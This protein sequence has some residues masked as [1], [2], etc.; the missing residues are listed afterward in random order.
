MPVILLNPKKFLSTVHCLVFNRWLTLAA[1]LLRI[2]IASVSPTTQLCQ[3]VKFLMGHY[4][5]MWFYIRIHSSCVHG[6][7]NFLHS[8]Q[9]L[10]ALPQDVQNVIQPVVQRNAY[11]AHPEAVLLAMSADQDPQV[12]ARAVQAIQRC[13]EQPPSP[14]LR[15]FKLPSVNFAA[16]DITQLFDWR[17]TRITEPPLTMSLDDAAIER[18]RDAPLAVSAYPVHTV[19]VERAV[20]V[21]T[22]AAIAVVGEEQRHGYIC[23]RLRHRQ[24]LPVFISKHSW[25]KSL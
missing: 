21:V 16:S 11:W 23:S 20:K 13:R 2:Y 6:A 8:L 1:R 5:P 17:A 22:E 24:Q 7:G 14:E 25:A 10:R 12:R 9:L 3:L 18:I 15:D 4:I 19:A